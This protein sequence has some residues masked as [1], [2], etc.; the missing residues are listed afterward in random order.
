MAQVSGRAGRKNKQGNVLIQTNNPAHP[1]LQWV[2][3]NNYED[4]YKSQLIER[5]EF[6]YP[7]FCR[8]IIL[9]IKHK[10]SETTTNAA[11]Y[12]AENLKKIFGKRILGP[13]SPLIGRM[14][15]LYIKNILLKIERKSS[16]AKAKELLKAEVEKL[17]NHDGFKMVQIT[18]DVDPS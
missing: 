5:K 3:K 10:N 7:P 8:L 12:L 15:N 16:F 13:Q 2:V 6:N 9:N 14:Q 18:I 1:I 17:N 4:F 11:I